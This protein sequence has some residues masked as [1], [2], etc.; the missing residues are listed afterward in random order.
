LIGPILGLG[1]SRKHFEVPRRSHKD[2]QNL[3]EEIR[4]EGDDVLLRKKGDEAD[5]VEELKMFSWGC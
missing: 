5:V 3:G 2:G 4:R 1:V